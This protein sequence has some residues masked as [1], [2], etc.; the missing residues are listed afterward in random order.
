MTG[1]TVDVKIG[2]DGTVV[3]QLRGVLGPDN[4]AEIRRTVVR[5]VRHTRP[6]RLVI[7]LNDVADLD[8]INLGSLAA[9]CHIGDDHNVAVFLDHSSSTI[10]DQL[11]AA[12]VPAHRLRQVNDS[13]SR[14]SKP[15]EHA[16]PDVAQA[17]RCR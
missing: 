12:G 2:S 1:A 8:S 9:A 17:H 11:I 15:A 4:A 7:D 3:I 10:A 16:R 13:K 14:P 5:A 6:L